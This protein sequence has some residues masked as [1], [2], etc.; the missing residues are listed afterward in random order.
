MSKKSYLGCIDNSNLEDIFRNTEEEKINYEEIYNQEIEMFNN[1]Y[2]GVEEL[3]EEDIQGA[4]N[5]TKES[6]QA[7]N[8][9]SSIKYDIKKDLK[10]GQATAMKERLEEMC[11]YLKHVYTFTKSIWLKARE[12]LRSQ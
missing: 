7:Y 6:I 1:I 5:L 9:W 11:T 2:N 3:A 8:R 4:F 12:D 10:R